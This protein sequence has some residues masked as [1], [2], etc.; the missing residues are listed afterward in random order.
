MGRLGRGSFGRGSFAKLPN[1]YVIEMWRCS[2][3]PKLTLV[4]TLSLVLTLTLASCKNRTRNLVLTISMSHLRI[5]PP[6]VVCLAMVQ[7]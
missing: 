7:V 3:N 1:W 2:S 6:Q 4:L 5:E